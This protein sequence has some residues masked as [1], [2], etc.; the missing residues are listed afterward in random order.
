MNRRRIW[1]AALIT[2][3]SSAHLASAATEISGAI[4]GDTVWNKAGSPYV[5]TDQVIAGT[6]ESNVTLTI[7]PGVIVKFMPDSWLAITGGGG[8]FFSMDFTLFFLAIIYG[9]FFLISL[10]IIATA[11]WRSR[12]S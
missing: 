8:N 1:V 2:L 5:I 10:A 7:E 11:W 3:L 12:K 4:E 6:E 9:L